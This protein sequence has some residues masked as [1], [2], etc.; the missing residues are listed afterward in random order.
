MNQGELAAHYS[1]IDMNGANFN[2]QCLSNANILFYEIL[3]PKHHGQVSFDKK[4]YQDTVL[5][6]FTATRPDITTATH[7][8][9]K[10]YYTSSIKRF[11]W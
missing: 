2:L 4:G 9:G 6:S 8:A 11:G 1:F 10:I 3:S 7:A 5:V